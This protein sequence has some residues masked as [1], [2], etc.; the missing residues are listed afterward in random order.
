MMMTMT[1]LRESAGAEN[2]WEVSA[3]VLQVILEAEGV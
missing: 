1:T 2:L 3:E